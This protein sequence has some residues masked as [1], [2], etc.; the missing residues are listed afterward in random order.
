MWQ[1]SDLFGRG[2]ESNFEAL[3]IYRR[4]ENFCILALW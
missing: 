4:E 1:G 3:Y 2:P